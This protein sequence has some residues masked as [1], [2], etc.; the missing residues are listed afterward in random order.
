[1]QGHWWPIMS[2][3]L[4]YQ[5]GKKQRAGHQ[6]Q[7]SRQ[8]KTRCWKTNKWSSVRLPLNLVSRLRFD[9]ENVTQ[10]AYCNAELAHFHIHIMIKKS[11]EPSLGLKS[12]CFYSCLLGC[13]FLLLTYIF[14]S[15]P[16]R[17]SFLTC[18]DF[19][20]EITLY[21]QYT[22]YCTVVL[23]I[24]SWTKKMCAPFII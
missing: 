4:M 10:R 1:M 3:L 16:S 13:I 12:L 20:F 14:L 8:S 6:R 2:A 17:F 11:R 24:L 19:V 22:E 5:H 7:L 23:S 15:F 9:S 18:T 21:L